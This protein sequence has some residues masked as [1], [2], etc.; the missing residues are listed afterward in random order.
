MYDYERFEQENID[1]M[2]EGQPL[3]LDGTVHLDY[4]EDEQ[5]P[6]IRGLL[7]LLCQYGNK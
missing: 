2:I 5:V 7:E 4:S 6:R 1:D 3:V